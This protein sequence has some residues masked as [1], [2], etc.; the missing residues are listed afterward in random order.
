MQLKFA[1]ASFVL[2]LLLGVSQIFAEDKVS[3]PSS[4]VLATT[5]GGAGMGVKVPGVWGASDDASGSGATPLAGSVQ[6]VGND[7]KAV[8]S[9]NSEDSYS[10]SLDVYQSNKDGAKIKSDSFSTTLRPK[11][12]SERTFTGA[13]GAVGGTLYLR[14]WRNLTPKKSVT[15]TAAVDAAAVEATPAPEEL[16]K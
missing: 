2:W 12:S 16:K 15:P 3:L 11:S 5:G 9:N 4:G 10:V 14:S 1:S 8:I 7:W 6:K 13:S